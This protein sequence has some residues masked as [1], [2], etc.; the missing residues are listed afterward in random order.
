[1]ALTFTVFEIRSVLHLKC[2]VFYPLPFNTKFN[3][4]PIA[5]HP[6]ILYTASRNKR[7]IIPVKVFSYDLSVSQST[8]VMQC[9]HDPANVQQTSS[10]CIQNT[11]ANAGRLL[12][13]VNA[14]LGYIQTVVRTTDDNDAKE[15]SRTA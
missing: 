6:Q 7:P 15:G 5:L 11:P 2:T 9:L 3:N 13:R 8:F 10:K 14:L 4:V 1:L 12:D